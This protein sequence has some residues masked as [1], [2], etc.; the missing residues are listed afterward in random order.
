MAMIAVTWRTIG[1][2]PLSYR[3]RRT[4]IIVVVAMILEVI[5]VVLLE[6]VRSC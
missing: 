4:T 3:R 6:W 1:S 5:I 2:I